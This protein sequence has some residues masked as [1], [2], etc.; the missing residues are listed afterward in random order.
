LDVTRQPLFTY[1]K[2]Q[3]ATATKFWGNSSKNEIII[4]IYR[5]SHTNHWE[6]LVSS[7]VYNQVLD[8]NSLTWFEMEILRTLTWLNGI[9]IRRLGVIVTRGGSRLTEGGVKMN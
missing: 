4:G 2:G 9:L 7:E 8:I 6:Q 1:Q 5:Y 3:P